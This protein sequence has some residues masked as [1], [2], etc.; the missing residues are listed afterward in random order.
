MGS[1][2]SFHIDS[3]SSSIY[4]SNFFYVVVIMFS[5]SFLPSCVVA[6]LLVSNAKCTLIMLILMNVLL[7]AHNDKG[8]ISF[9]EIQD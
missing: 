7:P 2:F 3:Y 4:S 9:F 1:K 5:S 8:T 6:M